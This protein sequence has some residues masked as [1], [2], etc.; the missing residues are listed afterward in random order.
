MPNDELPALPPRPPQVTLGCPYESWT[1]EAYMDAADIKIAKL[2][3]EIR[4][5]AER[6]SKLESG[7]ELIIALAELGK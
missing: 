6:I 2:E 5:K 4:E 1:A 3:R 7:L